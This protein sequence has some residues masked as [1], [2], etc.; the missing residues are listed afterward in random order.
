M[1]EVQDTIEV[2]LPSGK[3]AVVRNYTTYKDDELGVA[4]LYNGVSSGSNG[5]FSFPV[6]NIDAMS[7]VYVRRLT[8]SIDGSDNR[9]H[10]ETQIENMRSTDYEVLEKTV[11]E[12]VDEHSPKAKGVL[13]DSTTNT[14]KS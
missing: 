7:H 14:R 13:S 2:T 11:S 3:K 12:V 6:A 4:A 1:S 9:S 10:V 8:Q 5:D